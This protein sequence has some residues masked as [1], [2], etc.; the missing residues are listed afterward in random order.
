MY[1][2]V[3]GDLAG[4]IYEYSQIKEI[5]PVVTSKI[6]PAQAFFSDDTILTV[7]IAEAALNHGNY[8]TYLRKYINLY[9]NYH[10]NFKPYFKSPFSPSLMQWASKNQEGHS[11]GNGAMMRISAIGHL[12][13]I[14]ED[15]IREATMA[16]IPTHNSKEAII[17]AQIIALMIF[18]FRKGLS[19]D[20]VYSLLNL[21]LTFQPFLKFN[22]TCEETLNNV[23][24]IIYNSTSFEDAIRKTLLMGGDTDTNTCIVASICETLYGVSNPLVKEAEAKIP[25]EFTRILRQI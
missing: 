6:I 10:P 14:E 22:T 7:A 17:S 21:S 8:E 23:L 18:Y 16:T 9:Q 19:K 12:F 2:A 1:G 15:V 4:S 13:N 24:Y 25:K 3:I 11:H 5:K 20:E